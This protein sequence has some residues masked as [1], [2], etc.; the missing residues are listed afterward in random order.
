MEFK[1]K[2]I[3]AQKKLFLRAVTNPITAD[4]IVFSLG[5]RIGL[6]AYIKT[7]WKTDSAGILVLVKYLLS[8]SINRSLFVF[9]IGGLEH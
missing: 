6:Q 1:K 5:T 8:S 9:S 3:R 4:W 2:L 7:K